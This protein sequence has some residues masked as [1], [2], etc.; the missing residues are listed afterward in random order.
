MAK[1]SI[2]FLELLMTEPPVGAVP[3][4]PVGFI[5]DDVARKDIFRPP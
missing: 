3:R 1:F 5:D 4:E 2:V